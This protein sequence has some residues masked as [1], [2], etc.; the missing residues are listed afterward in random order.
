MTRLVVVLAMIG[1]TVGKLRADALD[2]VALRS[3]A[4]HKV[5]A[6]SLAI[7]RNGAIRFTRVYGTLVA[8]GSE[9]VNAQTLFQAASIS[10]PVTAMAVLRLAQEGRYGLDQDINELLHSWKVPGNGFTGVHPV[11]VRAILSHT[12]GV[13]VGGFPGYR[14]GEPLPTL[15]QILDG[16]PPAN[17]PA[18]AVD[19]EPGTVYRYSGGGYT[20]LH[21]LVV[22]RSGKTFA[23]ALKELVLAPLEM[24]ESTFEQPL[25][26]RLARNAAAGHNRTGAAVEGGWH[27]Y[28]EL[29]PD[30]LW[31]TPTDLAK[32]A[33]EVDKSLRG[34]SSRVLNPAMTRLMVT[35]GLGAH[36][37]GFEVNGE[38]RASRFR[39][40]GSNR[41]Y[42]CR[43]VYFPVLAEGAV[44][45]T[46]G[47]RGDEVIVDLRRE[48]RSEF[49]WPQ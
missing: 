44:I 42:R 16:V 20:I 25:P 7:V 14:I 18:I 32:L 37:L 6:A 11:T 24:T 43:L 26:E 4:D 45:M 10:K 19:V 34:D 35:R 5:P 12:V 2:D 23:D 21:L 49:D 17:T 30:G 9:P 47:G 8:G 28:P 22:E 40:D 29:A 31:S 33:V 41:G 13:T 27:V 39:H 36:G 1:G 3:L 46:N 38:G 48:L 15:A